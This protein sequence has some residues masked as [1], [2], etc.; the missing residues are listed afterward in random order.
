MFIWKNGG[1]RFIGEFKDGKKAGNGVLYDAEGVK[2]R[3]GTWV[4][5]EFLM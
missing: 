4:D 5:D 2:V 1:G 3:I